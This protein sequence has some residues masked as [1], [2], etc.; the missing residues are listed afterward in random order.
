MAD[1]LYFPNNNS[2]ATLDVVNDTYNNLWDTLEA[3]F[4]WV[5]REDYISISPSYTHEHLGEA[6]TR[7]CVPTNTIRDI[8]GRKVFTAHRL[9]G[10]ESKTSSIYVTDIFIGDQPSWLP[11]SGMVLGKTSHYD[12]VSRPCKP[13]MLNFSEQFFICSKAEASEHFGLN[14]ENLTDDS[15]YSA[16]VVEGQPEPVAFRYYDTGF[17]W[18]SFYVALARAHGD[19]SLARDLFNKLDLHPE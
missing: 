12:E 7:T 19:L 6:V 15:I 2:I 8:L 13:E 11:P 1:V 18:Q 4:N 14:P 10:T 3:Q 16:L 17:D 9:F 5:K